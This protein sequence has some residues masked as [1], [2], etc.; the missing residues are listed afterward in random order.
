MEDSDRKRLA[1]YLIPS[2]TILTR[3]KLCYGTMQEH[4][5][6]QHVLLELE[7]SEQNYFPAL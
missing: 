3:I 7:K 6:Q 1:A 4:Y 2:T 5:F